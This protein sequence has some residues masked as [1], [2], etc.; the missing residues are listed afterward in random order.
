MDSADMTLGLT[1]VSAGQ[2]LALTI[3]MTPQSSHFQCI[4]IRRY[5]DPFILPDLLLLD[6]WQVIKGPNTAPQRSATRVNVEQQAYQV[7]AFR[8]TR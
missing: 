6:L 7:G 4:P 2:K 1:H 5:H 3:V 8:G